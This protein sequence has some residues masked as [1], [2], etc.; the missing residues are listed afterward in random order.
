V[1]QHPVIQATEIVAEHADQLRTEAIRERLYRYWI[2]YGEWPTAGGLAVEL[3]G[4]I[5]R[6]YGD[7][8]PVDEADDS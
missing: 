7:G 6:H 2:Q 1:T 8:P 3:R 4:Y 5:R